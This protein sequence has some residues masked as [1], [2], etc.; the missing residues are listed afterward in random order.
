[1]HSFAHG[2]NARANPNRIGPGARA[3]PHSK[4]SLLVYRAGPLVQ[5]QLWKLYALSKF[6]M[7]LPFPCLP[8]AVL[9]HFSAL[10]LTQVD[11]NMRSL[12]HAN[13]C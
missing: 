9:N 5:M 8:I 1:M 7:I 10:L 11:L 4:E 13:K 3:R 12:K 2:G 6:Y